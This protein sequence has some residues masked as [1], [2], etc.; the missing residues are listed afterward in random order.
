MYTICIILIVKEAI[1]NVSRHSHC[2]NLL[3]EINLKSNELQMF[4]QDDGIGFVEK[5]L[6]RI[7]GLLNIR[8]RARKVK[9]SVEITSEIGKGTS[10]RT[11][12]PI[13]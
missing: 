3:I 2:K 13:S 5:D 7:N 4:I 12:L 11:I 6:S 1:N 8:R 10:I 9:G